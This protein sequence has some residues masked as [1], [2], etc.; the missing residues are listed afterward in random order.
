MSTDDGKLTS[1]E[2]AILER[3]ASSCPSLQP[4]IPTL[5]VLKRQITGAGSYTELAC[6]ATSA[7]VADGHVGIEGLINVP[8]VEKGMGAVL[9]FKAGSPTLLEIYTFGGDSWSGSTT[10]FSFS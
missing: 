4:L 6:P 7:I 10:G 1:F 3:I 5:R 9:F 8:G 2:S